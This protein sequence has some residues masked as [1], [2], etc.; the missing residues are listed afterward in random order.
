MSPLCIRQSKIGNRQSS[1]AWNRVVKV[2][3]D[4]ETPATVAEYQYDGTN[5]RVVKLIPDGENWDR[6]DYYHQTGWQVVEE[7]YANDQA[8]KTAVAT[9]PKFQYIWSLRYIDAGIL[10]DENTDTDG[11]CDDDRVY[12]CNDANMNVT[13]L[14]DAAG[15]RLE[16]YTYSPYGKVTIYNFDYSSTLTW[17]QSKKN[18]IQYC[19]YRYNPETGFSHV[20]NRP[21][22]PTLGRF[23]SRDPLRLKINPPAVVPVGQFYSLRARRLTQY[24]S[25]RARSIIRIDA[26]QSNLQAYT[27]GVDANVNE[28]HREDMNLYAYCL[29]NPTRGLDPLGLR[30]KVSVWWNQNV[31]L[32]FWP[33]HAWLTGEKLEL[34]DFGPD[35]ENM[36]MRHGHTRFWMCGQ[37]WCFCMGRSPYDNKKYAGRIGDYRYRL[38]IDNDYLRDKVENTRNMEAGDWKGKRCH[39]LRGGVDL[40]SSTKRIKSCLTAVGKKWDVTEYSKV[41]RNCYTF[42]YDAL[43]K[44]CLLR[45]RRV[46]E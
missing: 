37:L 35:L 27:V 24:V 31:S 7:R 29:G 46:R 10:R 32:G 13:T 1:D 26:W 42:A 16:H 23:L 14:T 18:E 44:C 17:A 19:G 4:A 22:H 12:Y 34:W 41:A 5:R 43:I 30:T 8:S 28:Q 39:L 15:D 21:Y 38:V 9:E 3:D 6:T 40:A 11:L 45:G 20:R 25:G 2:Q 36:K 33:G